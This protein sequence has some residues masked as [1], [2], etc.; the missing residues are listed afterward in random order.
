M[1]FDYGKQFLLLFFFLPLSLYTLFI[2]K[3]LFW[4]PSKY[5]L[6]FIGKFGFD[7]HSVFSVCIL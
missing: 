3:I 2:H 7:L 4:F 5:S 6:M 1:C